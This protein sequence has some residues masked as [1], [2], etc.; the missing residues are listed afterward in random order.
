VLHGKHRQDPDGS[1][2]ADPQQV[3]AGGIG[4][5]V[6]AAV[7][8]ERVGIA[9]D[10]VG[11]PRGARPVVGIV[12]GLEAGK[13]RDDLPA[14][15]ARIEISVPSSRPGC[16]NWLVPA[17]SI[18]VSWVTKTRS[19]WLRMTSAGPLDSAPPAPAT[20]GRPETFRVTT[21]WAR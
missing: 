8:G 19:P 17:R 4:D 20:D 2:R 13:V 7:G 3:V 6:A 14:P 5:R 1:R 9:V 10:A 21:P 18:C 12:A 16:P 15:G 11:G